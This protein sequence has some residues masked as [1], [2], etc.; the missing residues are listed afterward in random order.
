M[1]KFELHVRQTITYDHV[2]TVQC[3]NEE[4]LD[5]EVVKLE[6]HAYDN[7]YGDIHDIAS[8]LAGT[9]TIVVSE[10]TEDGSGDAEFEY[11]YDEA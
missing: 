9:G 3:E 1:N 10:I 6:K 4:Q 7:Y 8:E 2:I 11:D 5:A